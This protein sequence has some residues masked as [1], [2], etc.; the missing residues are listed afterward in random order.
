MLFSLWIFFIWTDIPSW[1]DGKLA[2]NYLV[3][4]DF[5]NKWW[6]TIAYVVRLSATTAVYFQ[7]PDSGVSRTRNEHSK[8]K[9]YRQC[10][11]L[12]RFITML[13]GF[14]SSVWLSLA[15]TIPHWAVCIAQFFTFYRRSHCQLATHLPIRSSD[16]V[17]MISLDV[18][19]VLS[20]IHFCPII[21]E[22]ERLASIT[23]VSCQPVC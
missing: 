20:S 8:Q 4:T 15:R 19:C 2:V 6:E 22:L 9:K 5:S 3:S 23:I 18:A 11:M 7:W 1:V 12:D 21:I 17:C 14:D 13:S 10:E 16:C